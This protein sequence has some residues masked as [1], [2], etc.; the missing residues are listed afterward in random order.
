MAAAFDSG[1]D[2]PD[3]E[4]VPHGTVSMIDR[5]RLLPGTYLFNP[6]LGVDGRSIWMAYRRVSPD[7]WLAG[8]RR[9]G[10]CRVTGG[11]QPDAESNLDLSAYINDPAGADR[12]HADPRFFRY[13]NRLWFSY[14]DNYRLFIAPIDPAAVTQGIQ[15]R[16]I[17]LCSRTPRERERNWGFFDDRG[18]KAIYTICPHVVMAIVEAGE[19]FTATDVHITETPAV[20]DVQSWGEPH[21]GSM[22]VRVGAHWFSF[23]QSASYDETTQQRRYFVGFYGFDAAP[24]YSIRYMSAK[25]LLDAE[26]FSGNRSFYMNWAVVYP[27][28]ATFLNGKWLV[29]LGVHDREMAFAVFDHA[30]LLR[31]CVKLSP[32][33][34]ALSLPNLGEPCISSV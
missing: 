15:P 3:I 30:T 29:S 10:L 16:G 12:W 25:P 26:M 11:L 8:P 17:E 32:E 14:H 13:D 4:T 5:G 28:G 24:P 6:T 1:R 7:E 22:P 23:F 27:S 18:L 20:W 31:G 21:G 9:L 19:Y 33:P 34:C 2:V